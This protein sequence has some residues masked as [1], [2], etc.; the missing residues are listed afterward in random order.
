MQANGPFA[1][2]VRFHFPH[3]LSLSGPFK[4]LGMQWRSILG[5]LFGPGFKSRILL[6]YKM[7]NRVIIPE[8]NIRL[9]NYSNSKKGINVTEYLLG[10]SNLSL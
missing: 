4:D 5:M 3:D 2:S 6:V 1:N 10:K 8:I 9:E 7:E